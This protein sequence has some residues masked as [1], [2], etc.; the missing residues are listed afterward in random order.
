MYNSANKKIPARKQKFLF[1]LSEWLL[2]KQSVI[3]EVE[4]NKLIMKQNINV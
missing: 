3:N 4:N 1:I 2:C